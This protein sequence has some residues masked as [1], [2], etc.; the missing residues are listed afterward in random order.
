MRHLHEFVE[1]HPPT[2]RPATTASRIPSLAE[3]LGAVERRLQE[4][5]TGLDT[6]WHSL[7]G[8]SDPVLA[9]D[10]PTWLQALM[11]VGGKRLRPRLCHWGF[12]ASGGTISH[13]GFHLMATAG[14]ALEL[15]HE[16]ALIHDDVMDESD[17]RRGQPAAH[18]QA[19][20]W[21]AANGGLGSPTAFGRNLAILLGDLTLVQ[22][23]R[24]TEQW[25]PMLRAK[26]H[27][28]CV[29]LVLGQ[30]GDL[31]GAAAGCRDR[32]RAEQVAHL[33]SGAYSVIRP[34]E[35][36]ALAG[37]ATSSVRQI[38]AAYGFH[39]GAAFALRDDLLGIWG[40]PAVTGKP[41]GDDLVAA[42]PTVVLSMA[43]ERLSGTAAVALRRIGT[44]DAQPE[45]VAALQSA[46]IETGIRDEAEAMI[47]RHTDQAM[48]VLDRPEITREGAAGLREVARTVA[49]RSS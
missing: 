38:L 27:T 28:L 12:V 16:F 31:T 23:H 35:L 43:A 40:D 33:K 7:G 42:K 15:L 24:L 47:G 5:L 20:M 2:V 48:A 44:A 46:M 36:G 39:I 29:E 49:W 21:H 6:L 32:G 18:R 3:S 34:L 4:S 22:A 41:A 1:V 45:D 14:A 19:T 13:P 26:W 11:R 8:D 25:P 30:R 37:D 9:L 17:L 10:L